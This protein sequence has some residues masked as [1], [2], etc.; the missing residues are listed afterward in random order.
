MNFSNEE[1]FSQWVIS[2]SAA[3]CMANSLARSKIGHVH[4]N[5]EKIGKLLNN[6]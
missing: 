1:T 6:P 3:T 2:E 5:K 4:L